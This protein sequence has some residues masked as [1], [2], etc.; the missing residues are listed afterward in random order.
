MNRNFTPAVAVIDPFSSGAILAAEVVKRGYHCVR[1]LAEKN[2]PV[3]NLVAADSGC[4]FDAT[5]QHDNEDQDQEN[6]IANT[7]K[8]VRSEE[9][10]RSTATS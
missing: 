10:G 5:I 3:A 7:L 9:R 2:S 6:A 8:Q 1:I 4:Q